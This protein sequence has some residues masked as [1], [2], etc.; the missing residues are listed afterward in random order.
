MCIWLTCVGQGIHRHQT[1][2]RISTPLHGSPQGPLR[3]DVASSIKPEV[4][5]TVLPEEDQATATGDLHKDR[6]SS[7][8]DMLTDR[9]THTQSHTD[10]MHRHTNGSHYSAPYWGRVIMTCL[11]ACERSWFNT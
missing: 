6:S 3:P 10:M 1:P 7:S 9:H 5:G 4:P 8:R 11:L 2:P